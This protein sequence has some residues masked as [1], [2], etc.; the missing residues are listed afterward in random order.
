MLGDGGISQ[1]QVSI[2]LHRHDD[3]DYIGYVSNL[4]EKLF[5]VKPSHRP[6]MSNMADDLVISRTELVIFLTKMGLCIGN[7]VRQQVGIPVW[8]SQSLLYKKFCMRGLFD[9]DGS[10]YID[11]HVYKNKIYYNCAM[12]FTNRSIPILTFF[13]DTLIQSGFYPTQKTPFSV[14]LRTEEDILRY[15]REIGSSNSKHYRKFEQY[16]K[17]KYGGVPKWS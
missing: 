8:I 12:N 14:F 15:F 5:G 6:R 9:T 4:C 10:F 3:L 2:T 11:R 1:R 17:N 16:F 7:K 13:K